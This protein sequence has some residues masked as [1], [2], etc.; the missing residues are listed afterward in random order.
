MTSDQLKSR[1]DMV[2]DGWNDRFNALKM[3]HEAGAVV[4]DE[5]VR[6]IILQTGKDLY[7][8]GLQLTE[9]QRGG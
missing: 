2:L 4:T 5:Q 7:D 6:D 3:Q 1:V 8:T 9:V